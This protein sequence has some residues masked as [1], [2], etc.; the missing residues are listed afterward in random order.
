MSR[1]YDAIA[2]T[3]AVSDIQQR[4][5]SRTFYD[6]RR[7][8]GQT[9]G[10]T[11][12]DEL[13]HDERAYLSECDSFYLST[14]SE[15]G[16]PYVQF[17]GGP[18]GFLRV[19]D[20]HTIG[21]ADFRGNLQYVSMGNL[22]HNDRMAMIVMDYPNRQRLKIYGR[23]RV[24]YQEEEPDLVAN[25]TLPEYDAVVQRAVIVSVEAHDWNCQQHI[26]PRYSA[27]ELEPVLAGLQQRIRQLQEENAKLRARAPAS[28][29]IS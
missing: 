5:G 27:A 24:A 25:L 14:V 26:T 12:G 2:F 3:D 28:V 13:T 15:T 6:R 4:Y 7:A 10:A 9:K 21:W 20:E 18:P 11:G 22:V 23:A 17:R 1:H 29:G 16:W 19:I 8:R